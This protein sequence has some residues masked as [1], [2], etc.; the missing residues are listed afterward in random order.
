MDSTQISSNINSWVHIILLVVASVLPI[1]QGKITV[2]LLDL[3][4]KTWHKVDAMPPVAKQTVVL[5]INMLLSSAS[6]YLGME[7]PGLQDWTAVTVSSIIG[8]VVAM[9]THNTK[10]TRELTEIVSK[11]ET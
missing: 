2:P 4:K 8:S 10:K 5:I 9:V 11:K 7:I 3:A 1:V 6:F